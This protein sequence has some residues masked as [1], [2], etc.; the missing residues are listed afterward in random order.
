MAAAWLDGDALAQL[1]TPVVLVDLDRVDANIERM[2][3]FMREPA[4]SRCGRTPRRTRA[5]RWRGGS[6]RPVRSG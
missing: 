5:W 2:A 3:A 1:D 6:S 4:A